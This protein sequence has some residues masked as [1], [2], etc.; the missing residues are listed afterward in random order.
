MGL[1]PGNLKAVIEADLRKTDENLR[2]KQE[3]RQTFYGV[4]TNS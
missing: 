1:T 2:W 4:H 3:A